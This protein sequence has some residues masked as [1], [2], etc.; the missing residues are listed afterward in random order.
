MTTTNNP[1]DSISTVANSPAYTYTAAGGVLNDGTNQY[2]YD[3]FDRLASAMTPGATNCATATTC[4]TYA[5]DGNDRQ[6]NHTSTDTNCLNP[7]TP[8][9][10]VTQS[11]DGTSTAISDETP[12]VGV[13][14]SY[15]LTPAE[16][17]LAAVN[18]TAANS[19]LTDDG[20][21]SIA[22][23]MS[24]AG[25][26]AVRY[27]PFGNP[28]SAAAGSACQS[29]SPSTST[30]DD[31][32]YNENK[33]DATTG[34]YQLGSRTYNPTSAGYLTPDTYRGGA[35]SDN[36]GVGTDPLTTDT[37]TYVNGDPVNA[38]DPDGHGP[39]CFGNC[40]GGV[41]GDASLGPQDEVFHNVSLATV[42][43]PG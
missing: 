28:T 14:T 9:T 16:T 3:G 18:G 20:R 6:R 7:A 19:M 11:F 40:L 8:C 35:S 39:P 30:I 29:G 13:S 10:N 2:A 12:S 32:D 1:D 31:L 41:Q 15:D 43:G 5:Y 42:M 34:Q 33:R 25:T 37:Y 4:T 24:S 21:G 38:T 23:A 22:T 17:P 36:A 27:D 26:C